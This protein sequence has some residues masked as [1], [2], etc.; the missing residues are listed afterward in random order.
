[1]EEIR[2][3]GEHLFEHFIQR[4]DAVFMRNSIPAGGGSSPLHQTS[5]NG[6][7]PQVAPQLVSDLRVKGE[8][9]TLLDVREDYERDIC[10]IQNDLH[11]P[12]GEIQTR[13][14]EIDQDK[15]VVVYCHHGNRSMVVAK[16][17]KA[18]GFSMVSSLDGGIARWA[19]D[20]EPDMEKY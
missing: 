1:M 11:I 9:F 17:L 8:S 20:V 10:K 4:K 12:M 5:T 13:I 19:S 7:V 6:H 16:M 18:N 3:S 2:K 15:P 14:S